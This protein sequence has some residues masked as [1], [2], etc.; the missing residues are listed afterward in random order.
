MMPDWRL[1]SATVKLPLIWPILDK[2]ENIRDLHPQI[3]QLR[4]RKSG[5]VVELQ[6]DLANIAGGRSPSDECGLKQ[7]SHRDFLWSFLVSSFQ[8]FL[9]HLQVT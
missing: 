9:E 1:V 8:A 3:G 2:K 7:L 4:A 5:G 6:N